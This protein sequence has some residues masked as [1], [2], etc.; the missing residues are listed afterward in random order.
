MFEGSNI[1][2]AQQA[3]KSS[4]IWAENVDADNVV[5]N[6]FVAN[7]T[8]LPNGHTVG[9]L[10]VMWSQATTAKI[11]IFQPS[12]RNIERYVRYSD[13]GTYTAWSRLDNFGYN[14]LA[15]LAAALK[16]LMQ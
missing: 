7:C 2:V 10:E 16:P 14:T 6:A 12:N 8:N 4:Y 1:P 11:Q 9:Y 15:E 13:G 3:F 5:V